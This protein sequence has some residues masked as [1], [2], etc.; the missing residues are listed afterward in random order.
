MTA[1]VIVAALAV[2]TYVVVDA[3]GGLPAP[4]NPA[5]APVGDSSETGAGVPPGVVDATVEYVHDGDTLFL[6]DGTKVRLLGIDT[7]EI[8]E[9]RECYG[10]EATAE[11]RRLLPEGTHVR[12]LADVQPLDQYGRSL[13]FLYTDDD[14]QVN[15]QMIE[16]GFAEA[17]VLPPNVLLADELE[18]AEDRAQSAGLGIWGSC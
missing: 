7:P 12:A 8:G 2:A 1:L 14:A 5:V 16:A 3:G 10:D 17:V 9:N 4:P 15:L 13:L 18:A 6:S 11:L